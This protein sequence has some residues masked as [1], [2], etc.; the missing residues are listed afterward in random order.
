MFCFHGGGV[1]DVGIY[2][3]SISK[4]CEVVE[5]LYKCFRVFFGVGF[6][7]EQSMSSSF[8]EM[9]PFR[10]FKTDNILVHRNIILAYRKMK[11]FFKHQ[12][13]IY[14]IMGRRS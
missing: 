3:R 2:R 11:Y 5:S 12:L 6:C 7:G 14:F 8:S 1:L 9:D 13:Y 4:E 10:D